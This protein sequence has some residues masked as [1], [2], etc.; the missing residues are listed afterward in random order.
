MVEGRVETLDRI[1]KEAVHKI[2]DIPSYGRVQLEAE[3]TRHDDM[4]QI[5][6]KRYTITPIEERSIQLDERTGDTVDKEKQNED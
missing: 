3:G 5:K 2:P 1:N 6:V 4:L